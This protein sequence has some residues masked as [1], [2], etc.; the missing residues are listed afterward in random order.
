MPAGFTAEG[1]TWA[2]LGVLRLAGDTI[3]VTA[4]RAFFYA[5]AVRIQPILGDGSDDDNFDI[6]GD[7]PCFNAAD[8][9]CDC[10]GMTDLHGRQ[11]DIYGAAGIGADEYELS[12]DATLD[13][14]VDAADYITLSGTS[15]WASELRT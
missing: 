11:R 6:L 2:E 8:P 9:A 12:G 3:S 5:E 10:S 4:E 15:T 7:S 13:G 1:A 14:T